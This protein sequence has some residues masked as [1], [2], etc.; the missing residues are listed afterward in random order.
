MEMQKV[1]ITGGAGFIGSHLCEAMLNLGWEVIALD[2]LYSGKLENLTK[3]E[4]NPRFSFI[5]HD[6]TE[7]IFVHVNLIINLAC[8]ASPVYYQ[9]DPVAT[10]KTSVLGAVNLLELAKKLDCPIFQASTSEVYGDPLVSPQAEGYLGNVNP[11]GIRACYDEGK[12]VAETLFSDYRRQYGLRTRI[13]RIFNTYG[14]R[15]RVDDGRVVSNFLDQAERGLPITLYGDGSQ[16][17]SFCYVDDLIQAFI[18]Y[19]N[20]EQDF[21]GPVNLGNPNEISIKELAELIIRITDSKSELRYLALP[22]DDPKQ[23]KPDI[24]L[25]KTILGWEPIISLE[26]GIL[27]ILEKK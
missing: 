14:P 11:I 9:K 26:E 16:T 15:M 23:R 4:N 1:L 19:V 25:A 2:N 3:F 21:A 10:I 18:S 7:Y 12:R 6:V 22:G 13:V 27:R 20:L 8:P 5:H 24:K 17:R